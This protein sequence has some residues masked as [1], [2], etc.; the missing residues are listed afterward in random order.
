MI[1]G[2]VAT[3]YAQALFDIASDTD[4]IDGVESELRGIIEILD[5]SADFRR[6]LYHPQVPTDVKKE[7]IRELFADKVSK[8]TLNFL[9]V[10]LDRHREFYLKGMVGAYIDLANETRN[11]AEV[12]VTSALELPAEQKDIL[13]EALAKMIGK[14]VR[15]EYLAD[16]EILGGLVVRLGDRVLDASVKRQLERVKDSICE[17]QVG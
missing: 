13:M 8:T 11:I 2:A 10:I 12:E 9:C 3:R 7:I 14:E 16:P 15:V 1:K 5:E 17:T 4:S 6:V